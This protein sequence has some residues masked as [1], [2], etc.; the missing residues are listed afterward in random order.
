MNSHFLRVGINCFSSK[1]IAGIAGIIWK[2]CC[3]YL[4][5][6][7]Q[8]RIRITKPLSRTPSPGKSLAW[9]LVS[10]T[11]VMGRLHLQHPDH[12]RMAKFP[13]APTA[14]SYRSCHPSSSFIILHHPSS[15]LIP[16]PSLHL[17]APPRPSTPNLRVISCDIMRSESC[18]NLISKKL[19]NL[20]PHLAEEDWGVG[21]THGHP[22]G[23]KNH[24]NRDAVSIQRQTKAWA[25]GQPQ[26]AGPGLLHQGIQFS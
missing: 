14:E 18:S 16:Y 13:K 10:S 9:V 11:Q 4:G 8:S 2:C 20:H 12:P 24:D 1:I 6:V 23:P 22:E 15:S 5:T 25:T 19:G 21:D 26:R 7:P 3:Y 17:A